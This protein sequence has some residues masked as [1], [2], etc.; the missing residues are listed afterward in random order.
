MVRHRSTSSWVQLTPRCSNRCSRSKRPSRCDLPRLS[1]GGNGLS[2]C[3]W[4]ARGWSDTSPYSIWCWIARRRERC[5]IK[6]SIVIASSIVIAWIVA[7]IGIAPLWSPRWARWEPSPP[8]PL[9]AASPGPLALGRRLPRL[10]PSYHVRRPA[11]PHPGRPVDPNH[12]CPG[13]RA[14]SRD[15]GIKGVRVSR[16]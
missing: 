13:P 15:P 14:G 9:Q 16:V 3:S 2:V 5:R 6:A 10:L 11:S 7:S 12:C 4:V 8:P 1:I